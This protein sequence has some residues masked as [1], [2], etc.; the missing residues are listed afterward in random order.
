MILGLLPRVMPAAAVVA[1]VPL[2][3]LL[4]AQPTTGRGPSRRNRALE[5]LYLPNFF[6][7]LSRSLRAFDAF[8]APPP[9]SRIFK[10]CPREQRTVRCLATS[11]SVKRT[12]LPQSGHSVSI[13]SVI[14]CSPFVRNY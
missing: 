9:S 12:L 5:G 10:L 13:L 11:S 6:S 2:A 1:G 7:A 3:N 8:R 14:A 4:A